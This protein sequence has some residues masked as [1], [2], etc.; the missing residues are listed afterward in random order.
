[1]IK[2][3]KI[4][5]RLDKIE[6]KIVALETT[7]GFILDEIKEIKDNHLHTIY[8]KVS[9]IELS[10]N[11]RPSWLFSIILTAMTSIIVALT[12]FVVTR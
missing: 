5:T 7:Q 10:L 1:M 11:S 9:A 8:T 2:N 12:I 3:N 6:N 4:E